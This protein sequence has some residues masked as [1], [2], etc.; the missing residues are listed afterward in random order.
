MTWH[1]TIVTK[2]K[3]KVKG[4]HLI[5]TRKDEVLNRRKE[6]RGETRLLSATTGAGYTGLGLATFRAWAKQIGAERRI[7]S[8]VLY[9]KK[10]IDKAL[11]NK[12]KS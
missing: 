12:E 9:D 1:K 11:D 8:R 7:A 6:Y 10:A 3:T 5:N 2:L 4:I